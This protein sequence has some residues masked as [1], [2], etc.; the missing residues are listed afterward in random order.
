MHMS[1]WEAYCVCVWERGVSQA[2]WLLGQEAV[3]Q[4]LPKRADCADLQDS[5][6]HVGNQHSQFF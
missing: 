3:M 1:Y 2:W 6:E 5:P 4:T